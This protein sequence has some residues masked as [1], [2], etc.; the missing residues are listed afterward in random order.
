MLPLLEYHFLATG[1]VELVLKQIE[2]LFKFI[3]EPF[4]Q[5]LTARQNFD[6]CFERAA[7]E[8]T[9]VENTQINRN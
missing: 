7:H 3:V 9:P 5:I 4:I 6:V 1:F 8:I 2:D